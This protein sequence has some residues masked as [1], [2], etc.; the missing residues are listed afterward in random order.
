MGAITNLDGREKDE[1]YCYFRR[2][3]GKGKIRNKE[4][5]RRRV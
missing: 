1:C 2:K 3:Y 5:S 4:E